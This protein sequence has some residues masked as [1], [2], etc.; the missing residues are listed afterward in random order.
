ML[1]GIAVIYILQQFHMNYKAFS[2][3]GNKN[4]KN[5]KNNYGDHDGNNGDGDH[6]NN[7]NNNN[8]SISQSNNRYL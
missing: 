8:Q 1:I 2:K 4:S 5:N 6:A 7:N 3:C